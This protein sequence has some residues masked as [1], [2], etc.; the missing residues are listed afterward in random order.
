[1]KR[2]GLAFWALAATCVASGVLAAAPGADKG[3]TPP[4]KDAVSPFLA[5]PFK[6]RNAAF[7]D[8]PEP[9]RN[10]AT[11]WFCSM[12]ADPKSFRFEVVP[13][14]SKGN[15]LKVTRVTPEPWGLARQAIPVESL[16]GKR[17]RLSV[18]VQGEGMQ[19]EAGPMILLKDGSGGTV[20]EAKGLVKAARGWQRASVEIEIDVP[21]VRLVEAVLLVEGGGTVLFDDAQLDMLIPN[22]QP[23]K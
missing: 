16:E 13:A 22:T 4:A 19:G 1:M 7:D 21:G 17:L 11:G 8:P 23:V 5:K 3:V 9:A 20:K 15:L 18:R 10:C 6:L 2:I 14:E 12:H